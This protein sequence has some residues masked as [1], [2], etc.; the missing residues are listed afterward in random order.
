ML[1]PFHSLGLVGTI[2][3]PLCLGL[4]TVYHPN[5]TE[6]TILAGL[7]E[8]YRVSMVIGTPTFLLGIIKAATQEQLQSLRLVFTGAEKCPDH[9]SQAL[10]RINP[11][12][13]LC[14]GYGITE[15]SPLV[16]I[17]R[18][19]DV[20]PGTIG[21][22][23]PSMEYVVID[24]ETERVVDLGRQGILLVRGPNIFGGYHQD[25]NGKGFKEFAGKRWYDTGD[26]VKE[27]EEG[28]LTFCGR[29]KRFIKLGGEMISLPAIENVLLARFAAV[30]D[31]GPTLAVEATP[32]DERP[33]I[34]LFTTLPITREEA[35]MTIKSSGLSPLHNIRVMQKIDA[36]PVLGTGKTDYKLLKRMVAV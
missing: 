9:T 10:R 15:C 4:T 35:N 16:S 23:M 19:E 1:P 20:R 21:K 6:A 11:A 7:I 22:V 36:I 5:P 18:V 30:G 34:V 29:Q 24:P 31:N 26:F 17:N 25:G 13:T 27:D 12:A 32:T 3:L 33:E 28:N 8:R 14:E 2:I